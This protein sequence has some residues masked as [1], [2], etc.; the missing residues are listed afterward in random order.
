MS[1]GERI[2][3]R[4]TETP[5]RCWEWTGTRQRDGYGVLNVGGRLR[6]VHRL[7]F[8]AF[9]GPIGE[10][11]EIGHLCGNRLCCNPAHLVSATRSQNRLR[12]RAGFE[13]TGRCRSGRHEITP[14]NL[15]VAGQRDG[16]RCRAC[17]EEGKKEWR[18]RE[19]A[20]PYQRKPRPV[21]GA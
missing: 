6:K 19:R 18:A 8:E 21:P 12:G 15:R 7:A 10:G 20:A 2:L 3:A 17:Y 1:E 4:V 11:L 14:E 13:L 16:R 5:E 9:V